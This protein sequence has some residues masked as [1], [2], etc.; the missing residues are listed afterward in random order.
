MALQ[1]K[2]GP[3][4]HD[5]LLSLTYRRD[6]AQTLRLMFQESQPPTTTYLRHPVIFLVSDDDNNQREIVGVI[7]CL[8][9][10]DNLGIVWE[11]ELCISSID[12]VHIP[13]TLYLEGQYNVST[14][15]GAGILTGE[16]SEPTMAEIAETVTEI[17]PEVQAALVRG[18]LDETDIGRRILELD[19]AIMHHP[20]QRGKKAMPTDKPT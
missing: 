16:E 12:G 10:E 11:F 18:E 9:S 15:D 6:S 7:N 13:F 1:I 8:A 3:S 19:P 14:R 2:R 4:L 17:R 5:F 20:L